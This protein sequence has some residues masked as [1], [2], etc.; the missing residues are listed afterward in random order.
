MILHEI[1]KYSNLELVVGLE[2]DQQVIRSAFK[3]LGTLPYFDD[4]RVKWYFGDATKSLYAL[5][6]S[7]FGTFDLVLVDLQ[8]FVADALKVSDKLTIMDTAILLMKQDG[9][10]VAKNEDFPV[11]IN[12]GFAHYTVDLEC[13]FDQHFVVLCYCMPSHPLTYCFICF[14]FFRPQPCP[15]LPTKYY[16]GQ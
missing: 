9:G 5:P 2:L 7:Y 10:V 6:E 3:N 1:L 4:H 13:K 8:T 16:H 14:S 11:R 15:H 12:T